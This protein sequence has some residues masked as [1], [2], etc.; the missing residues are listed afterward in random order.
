MIIPI[1]TYYYHYRRAT[2]SILLGPQFSIFAR[3][4]PRPGCLSTS[5][6][7]V[8]TVHQ[9]LRYYPRPGCL[10]T[11]ANIVT[12]VLHRCA[13]TI[14][15]GL[16]QSPR[17]LLSSSCLVSHLHQCRHRH[18][19][20]SPITIIC[21]SRRHHHTP[22]SVALL[23]LAVSTAPSPSSSPSVVFICEER[24]EMRTKK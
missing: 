1:P 17:A 24:E 23:S 10:T 2:K 6:V 14:L 19:T 12:T 3:Y 9:S 8:T 15:G 11:S 20:P 21:R 13:T 16:H 4:Y 22:S 5:A 18:H 7:I